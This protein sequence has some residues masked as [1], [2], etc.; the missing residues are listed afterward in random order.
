MGGDDTVSGIP[1]TPLTILATGPSGTIEEFEPLKAAG[2]DLVVGHPLD[3][4]GRRPWSEADLIEAVRAADIV[5]ASHLELFSRPVLSASERLQLV[6]VAEATVALILMLQ[7]RVKHPHSAQ[8]RPQRGRPPREPDAR[9]RAD[10]RRRARGRARARREPHRDSALARAARKPLTAD[11]R[12]GPDD[13]QGG[14]MFFELRQ[15]HIH[16]GQQKAWVKCM[17]EEI[18]PFQVK[19]GMVI[20][21]SFVG[22]EDESVYVWIRRFENEE[23]RKRLYD[24]VYQ[25]D[26][27]K[28]EI[29][30]R[31]PTMIDREKIKVTRITATPH[32]VI[33]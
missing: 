30:P 16:P 3:T 18:I 17:E 33:Q 11:G 20:L 5:L 26:Y 15:Y 10:P 19:M 9:A 29:S 12:R 7:K 31:V 23:E 27:W 24:A 8:H 4:P 21:G 6:A 22:E 1:M 13:V 2:L 28:T 32:S 14:R 25:S